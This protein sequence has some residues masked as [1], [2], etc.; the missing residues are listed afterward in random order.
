MRGTLGSLTDNLIL[1]MEFA[2]PLQNSV[3]L[4]LVTN[5]GKEVEADEGFGIAMS[6]AVYAGEHGT[7]TLYCKNRAII[8]YD[9]GSFLSLLVV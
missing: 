5:C 7:V 1:E 8:D 4:R 2:K 3:S 9:N 6:N